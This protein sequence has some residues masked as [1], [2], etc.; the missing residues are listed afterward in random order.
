MIPGVRD[1]YATIGHD[2]QAPG[3]QEVSFPA[4][5]GSVTSDDGAILVQ[6]RNSASGILHDEQPPVRSSTN[7]VR[8]LQP[9]GIVW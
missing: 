5:C 6:H 7:V 3:I 9:T 8:K 4:A 2:G 1:Q